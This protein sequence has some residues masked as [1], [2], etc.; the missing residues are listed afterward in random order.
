MRS[1]SAARHRSPELSSSACQSLGARSR[2]RPPSLRRPPRE[3]ACPARWRSV[4]CDVRERE[5]APSS[6]GTQPRAALRSTHAG[7]G[8]LG[9]RVRRRGAPPTPRPCRSGHPARTAARAAPRSTAHRSPHAASRMICSATARQCQTRR[10]ATADG[11]SAGS[12]AP[13]SDVEGWRVRSVGITSVR[14]HEPA[15]GESFVGL[16]PRSLCNHGN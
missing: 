13:C 6:A 4:C 2:R 12:A 15:R 1:A 9:A 3:S 11:G 8:R 5:N 7:D 16:V 10:A 14:R